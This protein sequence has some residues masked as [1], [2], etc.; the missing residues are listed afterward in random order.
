MKKV[1]LLLMGAALLLLSLQTYALLREFLAV[2]ACLDAGGRWD[3]G[4]ALCRVG[5]LR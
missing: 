2:D 5:E 4:A 1:L 3:R